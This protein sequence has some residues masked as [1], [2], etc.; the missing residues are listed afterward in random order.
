MIGYQI[1]A[2]ALAKQNLEHCYGIVGM[3]FLNEGIPVIELGFAIQGAG[4]KYYG[5]RN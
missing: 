2:E 4:I 5:Y 3:Y 1:L